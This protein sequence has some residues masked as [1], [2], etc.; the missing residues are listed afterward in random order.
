M[1]VCDAEEMHHPPLVSVIIT[2]YNY[3]RYVS[4][5][6][7][8]VAK[9]TYGNFE[10]LVVDDAS[11]DDSFGVISSVLDEIADPRFRALRL[12]RNLGQM[13]A[14]KV[15]I[16]N[17]AGSFV[18]FLDADDKWMPKFLEVH[19]LT[20]LNT[21]FSCALTASDTIQI[22][23]NNAV[24]EG[25][26]HMLRKK[27]F[28][29]E[30]K[31][32]KVLT[33]GN[34]GRYRNHK[35][36]LNNANY[37][38]NE[39]DLL[40][41]ERTDDEWQFVHTSSLM[42]RRDVVDLI[43]PEET[44]STRICADYYMGIFAHSIGGTIC[45][46]H[47]LSYYRMHRENNFTRNPLLGGPYRPGTLSETARQAIREDISKHVFKRF[48][49]FVRLF[50]LGWASCLLAFGGEHFKDLLVSSSGRDLRPLLEGRS[51]RRGI[52]GKLSVMLQQSTA[53]R[54]RPIPPTRG[55]NPTW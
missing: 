1:N 53:R 44:E 9:Q 32:W 46:P 45:I 7:K 11:D 33:K 25:T 31:H 26:C 40:Y 35:I 54:I 20:H 4:Q 30:S 38:H 5:A 17:A 47:S 8:S 22:D 13:G 2:S 48:T 39:G 24:L 6:I 19:V 52:V 37:V 43:V 29:F 12:G 49:L 18:A 21:A 27:R 23:Q 50:G 15:G 28:L 16:E 34:I 42:F 55:S 41:I 14:F 10:C 36:V 51:A 3:S